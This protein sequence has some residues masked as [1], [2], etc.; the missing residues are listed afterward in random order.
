MTEAMKLAYS[1]LDVIKMTKP[2]LAVMKLTYSSL[3]LLLLM[4]V[5]NLKV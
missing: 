4:V 1:S 2:V 5:A 3:A